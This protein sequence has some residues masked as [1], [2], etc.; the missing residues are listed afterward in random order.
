MLRLR[1]N[2]ESRWRDLNPRP[3]DYESVALP[4]SYIGCIDDTR[5]PIPDSRSR[6]ESAG[7]FHSPE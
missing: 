4:L 6:T 2:R 3:T 1:K 5:Y 7:G